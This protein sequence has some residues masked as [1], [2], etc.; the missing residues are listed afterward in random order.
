MG[1]TH[2]MTGYNNPEGNAHSGEVLQ[3]SEGR[4]CMAQGI[5]G[6]P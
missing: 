1:I 3:D 2:S 4:G 6:H 5:S